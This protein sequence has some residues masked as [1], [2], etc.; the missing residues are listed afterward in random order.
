MY[1]F[2]AYLTQTPARPTVGKVGILPGMP[3]HR[4]GKARQRQWQG[5]ALQACTLTGGVLIVGT[6][7]LGAVFAWASPDVTRALPQSVAYGLHPTFSVALGLILLA[8]V[9]A[10]RRFSACNSLQNTH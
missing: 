3:E 2:G 8:G 1:L 6:S 5:K 7:V 4:H 10:W 9:M